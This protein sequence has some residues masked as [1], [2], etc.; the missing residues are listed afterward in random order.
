MI[1]Y[2][3]VSC[4]HRNIYRLLILGLSRSL[5]C[6]DSIVL[7][8]PKEYWPWL[9]IRGSYCTA[10]IPFTVVLWNLTISKSPTGPITAS[11]RVENSGPLHL[12]LGFDYMAYKPSHMARQ[13]LGVAVACILDL[14]DINCVFIAT[15]TLF[16]KCIL[17][18]FKTCSNIYI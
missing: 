1:C 17:Y 8:L 12:E 15:C 18:T 5:Y 6:V 10:V 16:F 2:V 13:S 11:Q 9:Y 3:R 7:S 4:W 14:E